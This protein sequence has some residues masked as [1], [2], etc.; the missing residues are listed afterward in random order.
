[1]L[2][3]I[4]YIANCDKRDPEV[5]RAFHNSM[6]QSVPVSLGCTG[7]NANT[8]IVNTTVDARIVKPSNLD[9][10]RSLQEALESS[11]RSFSRLVGQ[12]APS[13]GLWD[14]Y[15]A[16]WTHLQR[17]LTEVW[18]ATGRQGYPPNLTKLE[19]WEGR[20]QTWHVNP[21]W[22]PP[23]LEPLY[24]SSWRGS[25]FELATQQMQLAHEFH[26]NATRELREAKE[27]EYRRSESI[28]AAGPLQDTK[29]VE[30]VKEVLASIVAKDAD[31]FISWLATKGREHYIQWSQT[32]ITMSWRDYCDW[33]APSRFEIESHP[34][35]LLEPGCVTRTNTF[36][37]SPIIESSRA[38]LQ[39]AT[40]N[41]NAVKNR[42]VV[43]GV[44]DGRIQEADAVK[45]RIRGGTL[46]RRVTVY[47]VAIWDSIDQRN[48]FSYVVPE[49]LDQRME[50]RE[51]VLAF[52]E[53]L[54]TEFR[55][56]QLRENI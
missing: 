2:E 27:A 39:E 44:D 18:V 20:I 6:M 42:E 33:Y 15:L 53:R 19:R 32:H 56:F 40:I 43:M 55:N 35:N 10:V 4:G 25:G 12:A 28:R 9:E 26:D 11:R 51:A 24:T 37:E 1:M 30:P 8:T 48:S 52:L 46:D 21:V 29:A 16:Q 3:K 47:L 49:R 45:Q 23:N 14:S 31:E 34:Q 36:H 54:T 7:N 38:A 50:E 41:S 17:R 5:V 22:T 13:S